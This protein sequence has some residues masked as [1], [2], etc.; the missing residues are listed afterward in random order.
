MRVC[1][2]ELWH[3]FDCSELLEVVIEGERYFD[4]ESSNHYLACAIGEAPILVIKSL[5]CLPGNL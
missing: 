3:N 1:R 4:V 5:K 2:D